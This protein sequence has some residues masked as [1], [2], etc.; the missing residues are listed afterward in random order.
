MVTSSEVLIY[1]YYIMLVDVPNVSEIVVPQMSSF[2]EQYS[3]RNPII[4]TTTEDTR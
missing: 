4:L 3:Q 2:E 1:Y